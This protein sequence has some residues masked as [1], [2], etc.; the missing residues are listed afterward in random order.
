VR[1]NVLELLA[2]M[3]SIA[4]LKAVEPFLAD[5]QLAGSAGSATLEIASHLTFEYPAEAKAALENLAASARDGGLQQRAKSALAKMEEA[6]RQLRAEW[7]FNDNPGGWVAANQC[8]IKVEDGSLVIDSTGG[9]PFIQVATN[10]PPGR[11]ELRLRMQFNSS[12]AAQFF[13]ATD[14]VPGFTPDAVLTFLPQAGDG[15]WH[16][17]TIPLSLDAS[18]IA[19]RLDPSGDKGRIRIDWLR[20]IASSP[21]N[22]QP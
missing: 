21:G 19:L 11:Y 4:A 17:Y 6:R 12:G 14:K 1:E 18:L 10:L 7:T 2:E 16:E 15:Q 9:D 5:P 8:E 22:Q 20:V 13:W 3:P